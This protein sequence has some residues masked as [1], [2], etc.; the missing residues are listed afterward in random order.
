MA[1][2]VLAPAELEVRQVSKSYGGLRAV[3]DVSFAVRGG[4]VL[5]I[6][7]PNGAGKT[8]LFDVV[9]GLT[10]RSGGDVL[11]DGA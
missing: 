7:G 1:L 3:A 11:L 10:P 5:G 8:T 2:G 6:A 9:T 4:E